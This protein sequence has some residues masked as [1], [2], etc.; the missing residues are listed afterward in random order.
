MTI[1]FE[2]GNRSSL[3]SFDSC[4]FSRPAVQRHSD[5]FSEEIF[6]II[7]SKYLFLFCNQW[8]CIYLP[9]RYPYLYESIYVILIISF[10][11]FNP[12]RATICKSVPSNQAEKKML[13]CTMII[14]KWSTLYIL[15]QCSYQYNRRG[16]NYYKLNMY[17]YS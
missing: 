3:C 10:H 13:S 6:G 2:V 15:T 9:Y 11:R 14:S 17:T 1:I 12:Q 8:I 5:T 7:V 16:Q 4:S